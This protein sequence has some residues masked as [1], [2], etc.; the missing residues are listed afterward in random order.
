M[1]RTGYLP[2]DLL[3]VDAAPTA[4]ASSTILRALANGRGSVKFMVRHTCASGA[5]PKADFSYVQATSTGGCLSSSACLHSGD[6]R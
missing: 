4:L 3:D 5:S 1:Q 6:W 2:I